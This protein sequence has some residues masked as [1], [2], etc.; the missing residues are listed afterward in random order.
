M[1]DVR[2]LGAAVRQER[3]A[4]G[5]T[6]AAVARA[7]GVS[8]PFVIALERGDAARAELGRVL[9]VLAALNL[10]VH[11]VTPDSQDRSGQAPSS[12]LVADSEPTLRS[13][14]VQAPTPPATLRSTA[15]QVDANWLTALDSVL[16]GSAADA[17]APR[18]PEQGP[19]SPQRTATRRVAKAQAGVPAPSRT[20]T[21][22]GSDRVATRKRPTRKTTEASPSA[23]G[24]TEDAGEGW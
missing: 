3:T 9:A 4:R 19:R 10:N 13:T 7:A 14:P 6:Q 21:A 1:R 20:S 12:S 11:L 23:Q 17:A 18:T 15:V 16:G 22:S 5:L 24:G 8:R 2:S